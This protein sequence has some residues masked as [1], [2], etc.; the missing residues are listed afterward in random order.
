MKLSLTTMA[1]A[2]AISG[3]GAWAE[4]AA[5]TDG[6][7]IATPAATVDPKAD[8]KAEPKPRPVADEIVSPDAA[9]K[10]DEEDLIKK[11]TGEDKPNDG[12]PEKKFAEIIE[13]M[14][15]SGTM[16]KKADPGEVTQEV[17]RRIVTD[18]DVL[19]E[20]AKKSQ[21]SSSQQPQKPKPGQEK[22]ESKGEKTKGS[23]MGGSNAATDSQ[24]NSG[25]ASASPNSK[26]IHEVNQD[27]TWK[28]LPARDRD[29]II[30]GMKEEVLPGYQRMIEK[31]YEE[32]AK[33]DKT[34]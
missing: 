32:L 5:K 25:E 13:R 2:I 28:N 23:G 12:S 21:S 3:A 24:M 33:T 1:L 4:D 15:T 7:T 14:G 8:P 29:K 20:L 34:K 19:I 22:Q 18:L 10:V 26:D 16:L 27:E 30:N 31:Y 17:Q 6:A 11:L 9:T